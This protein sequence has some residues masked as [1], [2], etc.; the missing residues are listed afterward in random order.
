MIGLVNDLVKLVYPSTSQQ[1]LTVTPVF[2]DCDCS[3]LAGAPPASVRT[4]TIKEE[5]G[6]APV[7]PSLPSMDTIL[8]RI[9]TEEGSLQRKD[10]T[11]I[12][13]SSMR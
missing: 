8:G 5:A 6:M 11:D 7:T 2:P 3:S 1:S 12:P 4:G 13:H 9:T 10:L